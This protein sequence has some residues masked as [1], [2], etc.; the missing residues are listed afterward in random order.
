[1]VKI[2]KTAI[3]VVLCSLSLLV[4]GCTSNLPIS[5][6]PPEITLPPAHTSAVAP[7]GDAALEY[8][9]NAT[10][11]LPRHN[12]SRL[13]AITDPV[14]FVA[15]RPAEESLVRA[16]LN[17]SSTDLAAALGNGV[18]L[19]LYGVNP[20]EVSGNTATVNLA[21]SALQISRNELYLTFQAI[22]NTL[23]E[24]SNVDYVNF[25]VVDRAVGLDVSNTLPMGAFSR[26]LGEDIDAIYEQK[27]SR[28]VQANESAGTKSFSTNATLYFPL[29]D[30]PGIIGEVRVC[31]F[32]NQLVPDMVVTLLQEL[33][34]GPQLDSIGSPTLPLLSDLLTDKPSVD[35]SDTLGGQVISLSFSFTLDEMLEAH[36]LSRANCM[37]SLCY[38]LTTFFPSV[39]GITVRVGEQPIETL[40]LNDSFTSSVLFTDMV[41]RRSDYATLLYDLCTLYFVDETAQSLTATLRPVPY[42]QKQSPRALLQELSNGPQAYDQVQGL[43]AVMPKDSIEDADI[44]GLA[45]S[46]Q[47]LLVNFATSFRASGQG[48]AEQQERMLAYAMV[49]TLCNESY[50]QCVNF[51]ISGT[52]PEG[53]SGKIYWYGDFFPLY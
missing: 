24:A 32:T 36:H 49:N 26:S 48:M 28:R 16:L 5:G 2:K 43:S 23:T 15:S 29:A 30:T 12:A 40:M 42:N 27:L 6:T 52:P 44:L 33:A 9:A 37:A 4:C 21:A 1:M 31:A 3:W 46:G 19:A 22:T 7:I 8:T 53:F 14:T 18:H 39:A 51:F 17:H 38:T 47:R 13:V 45:L 11:Y 35:Y 25:L 20:V 10:L 50:A 41:Q 34:K